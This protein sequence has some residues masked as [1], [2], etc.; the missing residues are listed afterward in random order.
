MPAL[1]DAGV[2]VLFID[3]YS[4]LY[5]FDYVYL[6]NY[7][8]SYFATDYLIKNGHSKIGF[9]GNIQDTASIRDRYLGYRKALIE[10]NLKYRDEWHININLEHYNNFE[11][12]LSQNL[13]TAF[14]CHCDS[15]AQKLYLTLQMHGL[16]IPK[17]VSVISFDDTDDCKNMNPPL[18]SIGIGKEKL[19]KKSMAA[20]MDILNNQNKRQVTLLKATLSERNSVRNLLNHQD[21][22]SN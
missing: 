3:Y 18:S 22:T 14:V 9:V 16:S 13:P 12:I 4:P 6:D 20:M 5:K 19:A 17:D 8:L 10:H 21:M 7:N 1:K 11:K 15:A 2:P